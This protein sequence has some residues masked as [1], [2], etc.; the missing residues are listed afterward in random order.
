MCKKTV[1]MDQ[2]L[3]ME[4][5]EEISRLKQKVEEYRNKLGY[6]LELNLPRCKDLD[7][8]IDAIIKANIT[9]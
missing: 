5:K 4:Q 2:E 8:G 7:D 6:P 1:E 9:E 3:I